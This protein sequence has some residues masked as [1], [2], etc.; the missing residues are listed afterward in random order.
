[1]ARNIRAQQTAE[2]SGGRLKQA[3]ATSV[4]GNKI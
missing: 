3:V 1:M 4:A 2:S